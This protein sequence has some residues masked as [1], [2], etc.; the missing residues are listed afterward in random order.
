MSWRL[1]TWVHDEINPSTKL[2]IT[3]FQNPSFSSSKSFLWWKKIMISFGLGGFSYF[4]C[5]I[6]MLWSLG[7][8]FRLSLNRFSTS[9]SNFLCCAFFEKTLNWERNCRIHGESLILLERLCGSTFTMSYSRC[10][11]SFI[12]FGTHLDRFRFFF[13]E[14]NSLFSR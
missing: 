1:W 13:L 7:N 2:P 8:I 4:L 10:I 11:P 14:R 6:L 12:F 9:T 3:A 5:L